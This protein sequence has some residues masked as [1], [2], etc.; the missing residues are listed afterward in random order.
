MDL[1]ADVGEGFGPYAMG[2]D[3]ALLPFVTSVNIACAF[4]AGD[5]LIMERTVRAAVEAGVAI[6]A[7]P[8]YPDRRGFGRREMDLP[9]EEIEAD[10]LYQVGALAAFVRSHGGALAHVKPHGAL[11]HRASRDPE[12]AYAVARAVARAGVPILVGP[13]GSEAMPAA[14]EAHHLR[15]ASEAFA[16][17][18]YD[19]AGGLVSRDGPDAVLL[20]PAAAAAQA[21]EIGRDRNPDT[22]CLHGDTRG[23]ATI[24]RAVREALTAAGIVIAPLA[25]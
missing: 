13:L 7:H 5:P 23:A 25:R 20:L 10:V 3:E 11:Y 14:A 17:R 12:A 15:F 19:A 9:A 2:T 21:V 22:L 1:N 16:D 8:G 4:H 6:G 24:A 18:R